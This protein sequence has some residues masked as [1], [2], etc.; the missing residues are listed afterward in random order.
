M[1]LSKGK[2]RVVIT[3]VL[4]QV[5]GGEYRAKTAQQEDLIFSASIF[6]DGHDVLAAAILLKGEKEKQWKEIPLT[7]T[8]NDHWETT[9]RLDQIGIYQFQVM[10]WIDHFATWKKGL[11]KKFE[12]GQNVKV[13]FQIGAEM[14]RK[15]AEK[16]A[17]KEKPT[18]LRW[19]DQL[20]TEESGETGVNLAFDDKMG[21]LMRKCRDKDLTTTYPQTFEIEV[22]RKKAAYST[23]YELF[24][25]SASEEEG[26]HGTFKDVERLL[27]KIAEMGFDTLYFPPIH[28][29]GEVNRKGKNN[30]L[31]PAEGDP[32]SPWAI[33]N[34]LGGH[35][36][37]HPEL[38]TLEDFKNLINTANAAGIEIAMDIAYQC[39][40]DHPYVKEH[41]QWFIWRPDGT[42]QYA[43]NP[44][45]KYEDILPFNFESEDWE[46]LWNELK[47]VIDYWVEQGINVFRIDNP[48]TKSLA[49]WEWMIAEVRKKNPQVLFLAEAFTR[50]RIMERLGKA[51]FNQSYTYFTWRITKAEIEEYLTELTKTDMRYYFRPNFWP[52]TPDILPPHLTYGGENAHVLRFILAATLSSNYGLYGP[53]YERA[54]TVPMPGKEEYIDNE[55]YQLWNWNWEEYTRIGEIITRVNKIRRENTALQTTW[56]IEFIP[57]T[58]D[59]IICYRKKDETTGNLIVTVVNLDPYNTQDCKIDLPLDKMGINP[60]APFTAQ[61]LLSD[62]TYTWQ[63]SWN[64]VKLNPY[65]M[66]AHIFAITQQQ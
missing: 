24:P 13:E 7:L 47:S 9:L 62:E 19:S 30:T 57:T 16:A 18:L 55:K 61:D 36:A 38:G 37:I 14:L 46:G 2:K 15:A 6:G 1:L 50:P 41:P 12:A 17:S 64:Y 58:N 33:G 22:E 40:P 32:G 51:G 44:P 43:E 52:N 31:T 3:N 26:K 28:P 60:D 63:G 8:V 21:E 66:P 45:K 29:I 20:E 25:R 5:E 42:V 54:F 56:N 11:R 48:H 53:P 27:P 4:P 35:K 10:G 39:A 23:W 49:F 65:E 34:R 59:Q